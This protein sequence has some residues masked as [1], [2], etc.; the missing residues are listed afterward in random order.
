MDDLLQQGVTA[1]RAGNRD[2]ARK[3]FIAVVKQ[4]P[5]SEPAWAWMY[6]AS[7]TD[8]ERIHCLKEILR[9]NPKS[10]KAQKLL[11]ALT[12]DDFPFEPPRDITPPIPTQTN[13]AIPAA[14]TEKLA[15][16]QKPPDPNQQK[17]MLIGIGA[18]LFACVVGCLCIYLAPG[19]F[20]SNKYQYKII[21]TQGVANMVV[22][23]P[24]YKTNRQVLLDV[25]K[26]VCG[27]ANIC[28]VMFWDDESKAAN[29][30]PMTDEQVNAQV[31][32]YNINKNTGLDRLLLC[33]QGSC[34]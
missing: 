11:V 22:I 32:H 8:Q 25:S 5:D 23:D 28:I 6:Q 2:E 18:I 9:I 1:F 10:E 33:N 24:V 31:A 21:A 30:L 29:S 15:A 14:R 27:G 13:T 7:N 4:T 26:E 17:N 12:G 20:N 34:N 3:I 16:S 19:L